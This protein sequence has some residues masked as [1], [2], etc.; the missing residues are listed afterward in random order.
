MCGGGLQI[1]LYQGNQKEE[2]EVGVAI[3]EYGIDDK[4]MQHF[5]SKPEGKK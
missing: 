1:L 5:N 4:S 3:N 2:D